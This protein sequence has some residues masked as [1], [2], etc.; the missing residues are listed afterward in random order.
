MKRLIVSTMLVA[1]AVAAH[2]G[3]AKAN[4]N[5]EKPACCAKAKAQAEAGSGCCAMAKQAKTT[6]PYAAKRAGK[7]ASAK[8]PLL[9]P[10]AAAEA[11][12]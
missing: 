3:D 6:C 12:R 8:Q 11:G 7:Q 10:K 2:A 5:Q 4:P 1:F 9:S